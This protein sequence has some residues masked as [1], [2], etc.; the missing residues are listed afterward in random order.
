M[1]AGEEWDARWWAIFE[2]LV[3]LQGVR[4]GTAF[5]IAD[6]ECTEQFGPHPEGVDTK[7]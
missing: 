5:E 3:N 6:R 4:D 2:D 7:T 1:N